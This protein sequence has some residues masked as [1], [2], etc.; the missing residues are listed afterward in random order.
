MRI[1]LDLDGVICPV[2]SPNESYSDLK[3]LPGAAERIHELRSNGHYIIIMTARH[4]KTCSSNEG[5]V[6][7]KMGKITI[8]W[9]DNYNIEYDEL[10]F[11]K[12]NA[13]VYIDDRAIRFSSWD[14][15]TD[16]LLEKKAKLR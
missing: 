1:V 10:H 8:D 14:T 12:P 16:A 2:K 3:P 13:E 9:L 6:L 11:G 5:Q 15:I 7:K 4:M